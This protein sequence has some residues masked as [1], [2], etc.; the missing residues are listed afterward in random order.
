MDKKLI[1][2][3]VLILV[4]I[5]ILLLINAMPLNCKEDDF[6]C[7]A[8]KIKRCEP[9]VIRE[10]PDFISA[11]ATSYEVLRKE[12]EYCIIKRTTD[13]SHAYLPEYQKGIGYEVVKRE[14]CTYRLSDLAKKDAV[15]IRNSVLESF[16]APIGCEK[17]VY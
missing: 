2:V 15:I 6:E 8:N 5:S 17:E 11:I 7:Q 1:I 16:P 3:L 4:I 12:G 14:L 9:F 10:S 13:Y